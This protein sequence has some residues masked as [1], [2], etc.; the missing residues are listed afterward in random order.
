VRLDA[1]T[2]RPFATDPLF[3]PAVEGL[4]LGR[5]YPTSRLWG[6]ME[7]KLVNELN[8]IWG[9]LFTNPGLDLDRALE[10]HLH[11]L[12]KRLDAI[13]ASDTRK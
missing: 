7:E 13:L 6:L 12:G 1:L 9:E 5:S 2:G 3:Q 8:E 11:P 4:K 10:E